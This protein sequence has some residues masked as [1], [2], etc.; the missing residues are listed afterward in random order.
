MRKQKKERLQKTIN[1]KGV[2]YRPFLYL[3]RFYMKT[4]NS[5][6]SSIYTLTKVEFIEKYGKVSKPFHY[7]CLTSWLR[8]GVQDFKDM[9]NL[10]ES[11]IVALS[12]DY[13]SPLFSKVLQE[14]I[15]PDSTKLLL[16]LFDGQKIECV[17]LKNSDGEYTAC[18]SSE[19]G[20]SMK[21][22]FCATGTLG[23]KRQLEW[24]EIVE[25]YFH[26]LH[27]HSKIDR[28]V[29][30]GMGEPLCNT[31]AVIKA[32]SYF[33]DEL[34]MSPRRITVST[35]GIPKGIKMLADSKLGVK[36]AV[37]IVSAN[38]S[39][40]S[41]LMKS[42]RLYPLPEL[43]QALLY[44]K[45]HNRSRIALEYCMLHDVNTTKMGAKELKE[46]ITDLIA[47]VNLIPWNKIEALPFESPTH[48]EIQH[49]TKE[50]SR[51]N[52]PYTI[53]IS[54][55]RDTNAACGML[56]LKDSKQKI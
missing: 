7:N 18:I 46:F 33:K 2:Q 25:Q 45:E 19:V 53:R 23:L 52:I 16:E 32:I 13:S 29:F 43:K 10:P 15:E 36:L 54:R 22:E 21:C 56:A 34:Q 8:K 3:Y 37:S 35:S 44:F 9:S 42:N 28:I 1:V 55:G 50:L 17:L 49:F 20:C 38:D 41:K 48:D 47:S 12:N 39:I 40:R 11:L 31:N 27:L 4:N 6:I 51:L 14:S 30:M 5:H 24:T 26:L